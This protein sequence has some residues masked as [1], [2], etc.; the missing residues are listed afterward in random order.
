LSASAAAAPLPDDSVLASDPLGGYDFALGD[1]SHFAG[2]SGQSFGELGSVDDDTAAA[3]APHN[4][5]AIPTVASL[6]SA[7]F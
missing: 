5:A 2:A 7:P 4:P 6:S 3:H 1:P